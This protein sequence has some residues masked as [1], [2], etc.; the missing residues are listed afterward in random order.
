VINKNPQPA[1]PGEIEV[2][3]KDFKFKLGFWGIL[4]M[5]RMNKKNFQTITDLNMNIADLRR[6]LNTLEVVHYS[7]GPMP[8]QLYHGFPMW[9]F[10]KTI[11]KREVYIKITMGNPNEQVICISFHFAEYA[12]F[13]PFKN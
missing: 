5:D 2:F 11:S 10:G 3:L 6:E 1:N 9:V 4:F 13:Y 12:M 7:E 8:D